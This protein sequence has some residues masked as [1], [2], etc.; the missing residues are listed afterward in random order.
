MKLL[1]DTFSVPTPAPIAN[2]VRRRCEG[3]PDLAPLAFPATL[4]TFANLSSFGHGRCFSGGRGVVAWICVWHF[5]VRAFLL[6]SRSAKLKLS[7]K[8]MNRKA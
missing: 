8:S 3:A 7:V 2:G 6:L 4:G 1:A 5:S